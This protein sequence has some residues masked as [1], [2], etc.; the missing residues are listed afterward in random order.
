MKKTKFTEAHIVFAV[1]QG[2]NGIKIA[3]VC[4]Y[5]PGCCFRKLEIDDPLLSIAAANRLRLNVA[6][7]LDLNNVFPIVERKS[8]C[9]AG[10]D[11]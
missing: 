8:G 3:E 9:F 11:R 10:A 2:E 7:S 4:T 5:R 6:A 1:K